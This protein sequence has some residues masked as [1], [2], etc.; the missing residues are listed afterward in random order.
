MA[1]VV[2]NIARNN[3]SIFWQTTNAKC[4]YIGVSEDRFHGFTCIKKPKNK[5]KTRKKVIAKENKNHDSK[6]WLSSSNNL[7]DFRKNRMKSIGNMIG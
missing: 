4:L 3:V 2:A 1:A 5:K 7:N 6:F